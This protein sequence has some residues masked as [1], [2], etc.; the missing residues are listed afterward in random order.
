VSKELEQRV[1]TLEEAFDI[2][3]DENKQLRADLE[4]QKQTSSVSFQ[5]PQAKKKLEDPGVFDVKTADG[6]KAKV[7]FALLRFTYPDGKGNLIP[8]TAEDVAKDVNK[9]QELYLSNPS[10]FRKAD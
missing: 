5:K 1:Q 6:K 9:V 7:S 10:L 4:A 8:T 2:L 3:S